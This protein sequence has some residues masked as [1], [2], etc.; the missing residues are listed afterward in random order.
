MRRSLLEVPQPVAGPELVGDGLVFSALKPA[1]T[2]RGLVVRCYNATVRPVAGEWRIPWPVRSAH[3][4]RLDETLLVP[5]D[6]TTGGGIR[7]EAGPR[8][9]VTLVLR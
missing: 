4:A 9:I 3:L 2:G 5:L 1:E 6:I 8:A 7:F